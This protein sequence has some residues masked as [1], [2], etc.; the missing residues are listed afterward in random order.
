MLEEQQSTIFKIVV[1]LSR[2]GEKWFF[3]VTFLRKL[4]NGVAF[5]S[6]ENIFRMPKKNRVKVF[7]GQIKRALGSGSQRL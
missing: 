3:L 2:E 4:L 1:V 5:I 6:L 7:V